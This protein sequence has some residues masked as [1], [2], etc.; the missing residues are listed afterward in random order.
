MALV[1]AEKDSWGYPSENE[2]SNNKIIGIITIEDVLEGLINHDIY[3]ESD[4]GIC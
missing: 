1:S 4:V 3:D 2:N